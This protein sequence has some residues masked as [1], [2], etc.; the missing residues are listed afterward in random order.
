MAEKWNHISTSV[1]AILLPFS[2][3][4]AWLVV[5]SGLLYSGLTSRLDTL[6][7][8]R[9]RM[10]DSQKYVCF[11]WWRCLCAQPVYGHWCVHSIVSLHPVKQH[12]WRVQTVLE[13]W[14]K[15]SPWNHPF[16]KVK[17]T[18]THFL[19]SFYYTCFV[20]IFYQLWCGIPLYS[21]FVLDFLLLKKMQ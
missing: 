2:P 5:S 21:V 19:F 7:R 14:S 3:V 4:Y 6:A 11:L 9:C 10:F 20:S 16:R 8:W 13:K 12:H 15:S 1:P 18:V 17:S